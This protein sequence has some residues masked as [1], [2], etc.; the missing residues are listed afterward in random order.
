M[1]LEYLQRVP[2]H[3]RE[4]EE[5]V[6]SAMLQE[7]A[8]AM[9][10]V[11][12]ILTAHSFYYDAH[13]VIF[14]ACDTLHKQ[15]TP[16]D[17]VTV[18]SH[19]RETGRLDAAGGES[20]LYQ[21]MAAVPNASAIENH[22][23]IVREKQLLRDIINTANDLITQA[24]SPGVDVTELLDQAERRILAID[25]GLGSS[26]FAS[27]DDSIRSFI[28]TFTIT[29]ELQCDGSKKTH[30]TPPP[31]ITSGYADVDK[32]VG[33]WRAQDLVIVGARPSVGK[34][35]FLVNLAYNAALHG[36]KIGIFSLEMSKEM[37][38]SRILAMKARIAGHNIRAGRLDEDE[39]DR[40]VQAHAELSELPIWFDDDTTTTTR[41]IRGRIRRMQQK[42]GVEMVIIDYLGLIN[43]D[44]SRRGELNRTNEV[45]EITKA[46]K[47]T[48]REL[49]MPVIVASQLNRSTEYRVEKK[50]VLSDLRD[51]G[52]IEQ[53]ADVVM[54]LY[55]SDYY[56]DAAKATGI[57]KVE[58]NI[59]KNRN[60]DTGYAYLNFIRNF[61]L[62]EAYSKD[63]PNTE[64][65]I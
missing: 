34:T 58:V 48:A 49:K 24:Y 63:E 41:A 13:A 3:S 1:E 54:L 14:R 44:K 37:L 17:V 28:D 42:H 15:G 38:A 51:S 39:L 57:S 53:D 26:E 50:P 19:L 45:G 16:P 6:L 4:L 61:T 65:T 7:P 43:D 47:Q 11:L 22:A 60:G 59:A 18:I 21:V 32:Y 8:T 29:E 27:C 33:G 55:R 35:A 23:T 25:T 46:L 64:V 31:V 20:Y 62:Y 5:A 9:P 56:E 30:L 40:V 36:K 10:I 12:E 2:P 52:N